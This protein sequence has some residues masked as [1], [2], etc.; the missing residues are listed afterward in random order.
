MTQIDD[1]LYSA[2]IP[3]QPFA[4]IVR[5]Y[6]SAEDD[7]GRRRTFPSNAETDS[8]FLRFGIFQPQ[9]RALHL[10]FEEGPGHIPQDSSFYGN[11]VTVWGN[12]T[13]FTNSAMGNYAIYLEGEQSYLEVDAPF[14]ASP[15]FTLDFWFNMDSLE[16]FRRMVSLGTG[17]G[18]SNYM[19]FLMPDST[20]TAES[21][22]DNDPIGASGLRDELKLDTR[23]NAG[24]W[25]HA[26]Y[27]LSSD[28]AWLQLY[29]A[30]DM[31]L[32]EKRLSIIGPATRLDGKF[33][34]GLLYN[35]TGYFGGYIADI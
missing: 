31:L 22:I 26:I 9:T 29:D 4:S 14:P 35:H 12:P 33:R 11:P 20:L 34:I 13:Y 24:Q 3:Q 32:D 19:V 21:S 6:V 1:S 28:S 8:V 10:S 2:E 25:Y 15:E 7:Q 23:I 17:T 5:Y 18:S 30:N 16:S 27:Q